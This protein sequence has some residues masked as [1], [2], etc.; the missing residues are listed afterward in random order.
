ME[1]FAGVSF[2]DSAPPCESWRKT[3][4]CSKGTACWFAHVQQRHEASSPL[5]IA[6]H[7]HSNSSS[8]MNSTARSVDDS[9]YLG[10]HSSTEMIAFLEQHISRTEVCPHLSITILHAWPAHIPLR[11]ALLFSKVAAEILNCTFNERLLQEILLL[12]QTALHQT[13]YG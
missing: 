3:G 9:P 6:Q 10:E 4:A 7:Q 12:G 5:P 13:L 1:R 11:Y 8:S 2:A